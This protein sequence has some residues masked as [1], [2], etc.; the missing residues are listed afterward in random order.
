MTTIERVAAEVIGPR[1]PDVEDI[2][3]EILHVVLGCLQDECRARQAPA[4]ASAI[5]VV[6]AVD[7]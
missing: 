7:A 3:V 6:R 2:A 5:V 1:T 4:S